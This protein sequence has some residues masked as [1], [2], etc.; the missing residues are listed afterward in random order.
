MGK[1]NKP[2]EKYDVK[3][4]DDQ[5]RK[6]LKQ[7]LQIFADLCGLSLG[8][9]TVAWDMACI[10]L[11]D[12]GFGDWPTKVIEKY[13]SEMFPHW[14]DIAEFDVDMMSGAEYKR[15]TQM[16]IN[17]GIFSASDEVFEL[18]NQFML[19]SAEW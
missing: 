10:F 14:Q 3:E 18:A 2:D 19:K 5:T 17:E 7:L 1:T 12:K 13:G 9:R 6:I 11:S 16:M 8:Y 4:M 15:I